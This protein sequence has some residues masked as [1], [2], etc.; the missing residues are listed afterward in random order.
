[1][2]FKEVGVEIEF[3]GNGENEKAYVVSCS[4][5]KY[6]IKKLDKVLSADPLYFRP[7]EVDILIGDPSKAKKKLGWVPEHDLTSLV[8]DMIQSDLKLMEK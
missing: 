3:K 5:A 6:Q 4:N 7:T 2:A 8:K 1:M